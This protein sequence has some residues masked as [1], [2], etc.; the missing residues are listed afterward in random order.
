LS[1][2]R[3]SQT[4]SDVSIRSIDFIPR[5]ARNVK[6]TRIEWANVVL[7]KHIKITFAYAQHIIVSGCT[8]TIIPFLRG[9]Q[10]LSQLFEKNSKT[11]YVSIILTSPDA[12]IAD[13]YY[14]INNNYNNQQ[15][16]QHIQ[17]TNSY[18]QRSLY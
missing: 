14:S 2:K 3:K 11:N 8:A 4:I 7:R 16:I 18:F 13:F 17:N 12:F 9:L 5:N 15:R 6:W 1:K 10:Y